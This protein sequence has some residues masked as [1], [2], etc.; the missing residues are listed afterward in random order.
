M[1]NRNNEI[2][3]LAQFPEN[4]SPNQRFRFELYKDLLMRNGFNV[5][6]K[7]FLDQSALEVIH[8]Y[9][10]LFKKIAATLKGYLQRFLL[11]FSIN[12]Y[13]YV[14]LQREVAPLGPPI[15]E[16][17]YIKILRKKVIFDFDDAIWI[18]FVSK[19]NSLAEIFE[20]ADKVKKICKWSYKV[21]CGNEYLC[22]YARQYNPNVILNPTC[23]DT[24][25]K[26][27]ILANHDVDRITIGWTGSFSTLFYLNIVEPALQ[28]L[29][30]KYDF[31]IKIICSQAPELKLQNIKYVAWSEENEVSELATCQIG[32]MP[33]YKEEWSEGKCGFKLI[34]YMSL[35]I[36]SVSSPIGVNNI[37]IEEGVNG[38]FATTDEEWYD[39]IEQLL[40]D[41][42][43]RKTMGKSGREKVVQQYSLRSN[44]QH[45]LSLFS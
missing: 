34:Q 35:E 6:S 14:F 1:K 17:I 2:L 3:M 16:W 31:D 36:P 13:K 40:L 4:I 21:S 18:T 38:L 45:F 37:I 26:H 32:L 41:A 25:N 12:K 24:D 43:L 44:E 28:K 15:F 30:L 5:T 11:I 42:T 10:Y 20:N 29:Q 27:N 22:N 19:Q 9:G 33:L 7:S 8:K 23:V 39:S